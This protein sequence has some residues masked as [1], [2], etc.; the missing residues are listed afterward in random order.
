MTYAQQ[1]AIFTAALALSGAGLLLAQ[2]VPPNPVDPCG[3]PK[4]CDE[5]QSG[6]KELSPTSLNCKAM[7]IVGATVDTA[8]FGTYSFVADE[9]Q[10]CAERYIGT[11]TAGGDCLLDARCINYDGESGARLAEDVCDPAS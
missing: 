2:I 9:S 10:K 8:T 4:N 5:S 3:L 7:V 1:L 11:R 6:C